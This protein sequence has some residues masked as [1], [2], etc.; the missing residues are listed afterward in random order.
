MTVTCV[1]GGGGVLIVPLALIS[2]TESR[3]ARAGGVT[4]KR[5]GPERRDGLADA[6]APLM[7]LRSSP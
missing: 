7:R 6:V 5:N 1:A 3:P 2:L 4:D